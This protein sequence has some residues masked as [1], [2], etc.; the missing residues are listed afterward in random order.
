MSACCGPDRAAGP[1][2]APVAEAEFAVPA[3]TR[4]DILRGMVRIPGGPFLMG[5]DDA[6]AVP[7]D[8]E[9]PVREVTVSAF[10]IDEA[11]VTNA[12]F[13]RFVK[14]TGYRTEAE[15][16][17]WSYVF[18][19]FVPPTAQASV[20]PGTVPGAPWWR[21]VEG[22]YWRAPE[23]PGSSVGERG[24][25]PVV[26]VSWHDASA[27]ARWAGKRL[28]TEAEWEKA[29]RGGLVQARFPWGDE[30]SPRGRHRC[31]IWRGRFPTHNTGEDGHVGTAP[32]NAFGANG[33]GLYNTSGNVWEWCA[34]RFSA[35]WHAAD[36]PETRTDPAGPPEGANR[37]LR[38]GSHLCHHTYC[39]RYRVA[40][41]TANAP[42]SSTGHGGF[43]C[44]VSVSALPGH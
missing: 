25:H 28:P 8:G 12:R 18:G 17:G 33:Y 36:R 22:A 14:A 31:N 38:G 23:G 41:R 19:P 9:G 4:T 29:A 44:A 26:H 43:R 6:D 39:N 35:D 11:C 13:A 37:V 42:D 30:L 10:H 24:H 5:G 34:D 7:V 20:L 27:Y 32:V 15:R 40:A 16:F 21:A 2:A 3:R 1:T